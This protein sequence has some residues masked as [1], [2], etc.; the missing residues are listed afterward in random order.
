MCDRCNGRH[1]SWVHIA[2]TW[3]KEEK[4]MMMKYLEEDVIDEINKEYLQRIYTE[5]KE[6]FTD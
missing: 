2:D 6:G 5:E 4:V 3:T 1:K